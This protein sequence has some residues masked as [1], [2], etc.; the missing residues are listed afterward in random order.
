MRGK[1]LLEQKRC[2]YNVGMPILDN[3]LKELT[4]YSYQI[5]SFNV[6]D[7]ELTVRATHKD[8]KKHNVHLTFINVH[9]LQMPNI[10][11]GTMSVC[12]DDE[13]LEVAGKTDLHETIMKI[14]ER[15]EYLEHFKKLFTLYKA[16]TEH[17]TVYVL[18]KLITVEQD[19]D[20]IY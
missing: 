9:Y 18:G 8:K 4:G 5:W 12:S 13:M 20:P 15:D 17:S 1:N 6:V 7:S 2:V 11:M 19:V 3:E 10:W 16:N 14:T